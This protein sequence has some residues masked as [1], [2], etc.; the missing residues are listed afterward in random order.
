[1]TLHIQCP[2]TNFAPVSICHS[3]ATRT[4]QNRTSDWKDRDIMAYTGVNVLTF[5]L[6]GSTCMWW[7]ERESTEARVLDGE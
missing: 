5:S 2:L 4:E 1:M 6:K 3:K 7:E